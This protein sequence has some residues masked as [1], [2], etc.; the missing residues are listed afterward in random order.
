MISANPLFSI[1]IATK[2]RIPFCISAIK[3]ILNSTETDFE[4]V[5]QDNSDTKELSNYIADNISDRRLIYNY[6]PPPFSSI[7][8]F[9]AV[10][11]A[12]TGEFVCLIGDDDGINPDIFK[13]VRWANVNGLTAIV[14]S[15]N[16]VYHWP[17]S[18]ILLKGNN[19]DN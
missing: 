5:V 16:S 4:L 2:N 19:K 3:L 7:D 15:F 17:D 18:G 14:P 12:A 1:L 10:L 11:E 13:M 8:N 6:T 9:N